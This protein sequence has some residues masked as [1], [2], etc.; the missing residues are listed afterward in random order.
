MCSMLASRT[1]RS[2]DFSG[3]MLDVIR[4]NEIGESVEARLAL[5][6]LKLIFTLAFTLYETG[7]SL[8][9]FEQ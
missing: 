6:R 9:N 7:K 5:S 4:G 3:A 2:L 1:R 8:K